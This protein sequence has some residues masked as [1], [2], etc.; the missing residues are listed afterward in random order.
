MLGVV[1]AGGK[2]ERLKPLSSRTPKSFLKLA[3]KPLY[4]YAVEEIEEAGVDDV[5][6]VTREEWMPRVQGGLKVV[7]QKGPG[8]DSAFRTA[9]EYAAVEGYET[10]LVVLSGFLASPRGMSS[11]AV[12]FYTGSGYSVVLSVVPVV[13]GLE[14]YGFVD[15]EPSGHVK[16]VYDPFDVKSVPQAPGYVFAGVVVGSVR[17]L[18]RVGEL[19][20]FIGLLNKLAS[21]GSVGG[22]VWSGDWAEIG[23]PWDIL[24]A[25]EIALK[26]AKPLISPKASIARTAA[27]EGYVSIMDEALV[28][29]NAVVKGPVYVG[30]GARV[31]AGSVVEGPA[32]IEDGA[33]VG[34]NSVV[35]GSV[36][37]EGA[38]IEA[39]CFVENSVIGEGARIGP[40]SVFTAGRPVN[41]PERFKP[42]IEGAASDIRLG[43][44]VAPGEVVRPH[45]VEGGGRVIE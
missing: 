4:Q 45:T 38:R 30:R 28:G 44:V 42:V 1:L 21:E 43:V 32:V 18:R 17:A 11:Y 20:G 16:R 40:L 10:I 35:K 24:L 22:V 26:L 41:L 31:E 29:E 27:L 12:D 13:T 5:V 39:G 6:V 23:Y 8:F 19:G 36:V 25:Q 33:V 14:T 7:P 9:V 37:M 3:G 2:G 15:M 34:P